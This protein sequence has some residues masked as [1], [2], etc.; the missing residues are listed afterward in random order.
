LDEHAHAYQDYQRK[1][2]EEYIR[3]WDYDLVC[4]ELKTTPIKIVKYNYSLE[5]NIQ[6]H[7]QFD[8]TLSLSEDG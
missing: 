6:N 4:D 5:E 3:K 8:G 1:Y 2:S 7:L